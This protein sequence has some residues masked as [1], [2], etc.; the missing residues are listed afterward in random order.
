MLMECCHYLQV[1]DEAQVLSANSDLV[2][3]VHNRCAVFYMPLLIFPRPAGASQ[4]KDNWQF[5][6]LLFHLMSLGGRVSSHSMAQAK[7]H[8]YLSMH[9][10]TH[11]CN[12]HSSNIIRL[13]PLIDIMAQ[14]HF[15]FMPVHQWAQRIM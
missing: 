10:C 4:S 15:R 2:C 7:M 3:L 11:A 8:T 5:M 9:S 13:T 6:I 12:S 14:C 1:W